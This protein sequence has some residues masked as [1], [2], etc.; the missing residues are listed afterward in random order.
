MANAF[1]TLKLKH[2]G[3]LRSSALRPARRGAVAVG[4]VGDDVLLFKITA[5]GYGHP[6]HSGATV[7]PP[8]ISENLA[9]SRVAW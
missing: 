2:A 8:L 7:G 6:R 5:E 1:R 3:T 4:H 9:R